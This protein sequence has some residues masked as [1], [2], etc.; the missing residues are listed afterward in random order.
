L[1]H[2]TDCASMSRGLIS[3]SLMGLGVM[4]THVWCAWPVNHHM[5]NFISTTPQNIAFDIA[6]PWTAICSIASPSLLQV[7]PLHWSSTRL[8]RVFDSAVRSPISEEE[9]GEA[10]AAVDAMAQQDWF[11]R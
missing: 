11:P 3:C 4:H 9:M 5:Y 2:V 10:A 7:E 1:R 8:R 6:S